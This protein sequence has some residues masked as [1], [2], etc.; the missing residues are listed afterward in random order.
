MNILKDLNKKGK[1]LV[2]VTHDDNIASQ[3]SRIVNICD[4]KIVSV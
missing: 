1:T 3:C 4:G 2:I